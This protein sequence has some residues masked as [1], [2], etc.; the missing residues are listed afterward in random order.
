MKIFLKVKTKAR[1]QKVQQIDETNYVVHVKSLPVDGKANKEII[2][3]LSEHFQV[4]KSNIQ[5]LTGETSKQKI[6]EI[7]K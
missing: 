4:S 1:E 5:F 3:V 2:E 7:I 6:I